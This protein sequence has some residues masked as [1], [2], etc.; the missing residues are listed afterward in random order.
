MTDTNRDARPDSFHAQRQTIATSPA[1]RPWPLVTAA[2]ACIAGVI[3]GSLGAWTVFER[4]SETAPDT[5]AI[6]G[7]RSDGLFAALFAAVA[8]I[9]L[10]VALL[11]EGNEPWAWPARSARRQPG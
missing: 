7:H 5:W 6:P 1:A 8:L 3:A 10:G 2:V 9:S 11:R 4:I